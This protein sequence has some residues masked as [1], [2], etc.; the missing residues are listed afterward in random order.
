MAQVAWA[1]ETLG[2]FGSMRGSLLGHNFILRDLGEKS[3]VE[4]DEYKATKTS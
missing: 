3:G 1:R 4:A 2:N